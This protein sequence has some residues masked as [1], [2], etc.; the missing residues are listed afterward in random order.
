MYCNVP[1]NPV[2]EPHTHTMK[3]WK[4]LCITLFTLLFTSC[5]GL[6]GPRDLVLPLARLQAALDRRFPLDQ[7]YLDMV[8][9]RIT[10]PRLRL[11]PETNRLE[12][13]FDAQ[14]A[15]PLFGQAWNGSI[16]VSGE[17]KIDAGRNA[18]VLAAP[19]VERFQLDG[20]DARLAER[21]GRVGAV[22][23]EKMLEDMP[24]YTFRPEDL[25]HA[26][27]DFVAR[28]IR[29]RADALVVSFAPAH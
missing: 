15:P 20:V 11:Q 13:S 2:P 19:R 24:L 18:V 29:T 12:T 4:T 28:T 16:T 17:L 5:A 8:D 3:I 10:H 27:T 21:L 7:R 14:I 9:V 26:G 22:L 6:L 1:Q 23:V 25:R